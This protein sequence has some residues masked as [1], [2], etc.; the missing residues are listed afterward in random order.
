[1]GLIYHVFIAIKWQFQ[2]VSIVNDITIFAMTQPIYEL[3]KNNFDVKCSTV[4][5]TC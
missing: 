2:K 3:K 5:V 4:H 1:M